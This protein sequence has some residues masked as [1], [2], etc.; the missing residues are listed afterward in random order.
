MSAHT[1]ANE[2]DWDNMTDDEIIALFDEMQAI[3][4][5]KWGVPEDDDDEQ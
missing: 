1:P 2:P 3:E 5:H 4:D